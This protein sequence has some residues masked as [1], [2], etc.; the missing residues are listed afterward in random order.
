P[1]RRHD[2]PTEL[3]TFFGPVIYKY[4][5]STRLI[6][7]VLPTNLSQPRERALCARSLGFG[8][9]HCRVAA[10]ERRPAFQGRSR[11]P[12]PIPRRRATDEIA[13]PNGGRGAASRRGRPGTGLERPAYCQAPRCGGETGV[14]V[15]SKSHLSTKRLFHGRNFVTVGI[16][17]RLVVWA[18]PKMSNLH[19]PAGR[20]P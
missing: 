16:S 7:L 20:V 10:S 18:R 6:V 1:A 11:Q 15:P 3:C 5:A 13:N 19:T 12:N 9:F 14:S 17:I 2:A 8:H 4:F